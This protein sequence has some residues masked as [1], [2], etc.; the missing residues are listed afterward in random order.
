MYC[1][2]FTDDERNM[3]GRIMSRLKM[4]PF[5]WTHRT[6]SDF[7]SISPKSVH[8]FIMKVRTP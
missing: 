6:L 3:I 2:K 5:Y 7:W 4:K 1:A 8:D